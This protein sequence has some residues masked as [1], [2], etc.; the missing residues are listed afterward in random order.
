MARKLRRRWR[1]KRRS[2]AD[3]NAPFACG[4]N[5]PYDKSS[6][7]HRNPFGKGSSTSFQLTP[8]RLRERLRRKRTTPLST[9]REVR[10]TTRADSSI[11]LW[12]QAFLFSPSDRPKDISE[13]LS[14]QKLLH[15]HLERP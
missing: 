1:A 2:V 10:P 11:R 14:S 9:A 7:D 13:R 3:P 6:V 8:G 4:R 5:E 12:S 15:P